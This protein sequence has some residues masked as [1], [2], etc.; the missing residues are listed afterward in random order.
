MSP[1]GRCKSKK[2]CEDIS[3]DDWNIEVEVGNHNSKAKL[4]DKYV[5]K[6]LIPNVQYQ[7]YLGDL[8]SLDGTH[9]KNIEGRT[10]KGQGIVRDILYILN[11]IYLGDCYFKTLITLVSAM[12]ITVLTH[13]SEIWLNLTEKNLRSLE[14][15]D[16]QLLRSALMTN[17]KTSICLLMLELGLIPV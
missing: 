4:T 5:G 2:P 17:S 13:N 14:S 3:I 15:E 8:I 16:C 1:T 9:N 7:N 12:L 6:A 10:A 11:G